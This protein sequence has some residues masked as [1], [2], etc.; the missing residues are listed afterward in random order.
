MTVKELIEHLEELPMDY[1]IVTDEGEV[2]LVLVRDEIYFTEDHG[3]RE[4][5]IVKLY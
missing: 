4:G 1:P 5:P 2:T 3:Y